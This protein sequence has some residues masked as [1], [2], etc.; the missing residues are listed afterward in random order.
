MFTMLPKT[1]LMTR[2]T[3]RKKLTHLEELEEHSF[4]VQWV[5]NDRGV[6][7]RCLNIFTKLPCTDLEAFDIFIIFSTKTKVQHGLCYCFSL[8]DHRGP[9]KDIFLAMTKRRCNMWAVSSWPSWVS[10]SGALENSGPCCFL[11]PS[12]GGYDCTRIMVVSGFTCKR[13]QFQWLSKWKKSQLTK[14]IMV[15]YTS[16]S[17]TVYWVYIF[18][19]YLG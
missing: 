13:L 8:P 3:K 18:I 19:K 5:L 4:T 7:W 15:V 10:L 9:T 14:K 16:P 2:K 12:R 17:A 1:P 6:N 11:L